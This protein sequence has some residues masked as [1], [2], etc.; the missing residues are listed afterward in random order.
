M[1]KTQRNNARRRSRRAN[2]D[3][4]NVLV[5]PMTQLRFSPTNPGRVLLRGVVELFNGSTILVLSYTNFNA[6]FSQAR[7]VLLP[8]AY[9]R[10]ND[11]KVSVK[12][13]GGTASACSA[14]YNISNAPDS[15]GSAVAILNDDYAAMASAGVSPTI[16]PPTIYWKEGSRVWYRAVDQ[17]AGAPTNEDLVAGT[18]CINGSGG[19]TGVTVIGW[20]VVEVELQFHTLG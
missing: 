12:I 1:S 7:S 8:F 10:V 4:R 14:V 18:V 9:F 17:V 11:A 19:A 6:W 5:N 16:H 13:T 3:N 15:D 2:T 20:A